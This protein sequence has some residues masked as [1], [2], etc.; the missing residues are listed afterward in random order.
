MIKY[1]DVGKIGI[2]TDTKGK[3]C[4]QCVF[5]RYINRDLK[6][7]CILIGGKL[8]RDGD[9]FMR[10]EKCKECEVKCLKS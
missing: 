6:Y 4:N 3:Y 7:R 2:L 8:E 1:I 10:L 9:N 5:K